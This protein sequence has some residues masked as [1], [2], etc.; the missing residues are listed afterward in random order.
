M[1]QIC[2]MDALESIKAAIWEVLPTTPVDEVCT[3]AEKLVDD[4][5]ERT[6]D[7]R[8]VLPEDLDLLKPIQQRK[9]IQAWKE[10]ESK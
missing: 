4:G 1:T 8:Y 9:L 10:K 3:L 5:V 7:L 6:S 2:S